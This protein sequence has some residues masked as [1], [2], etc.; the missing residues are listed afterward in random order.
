MNK[1]TVKIC[2]MFKIDD[3][4]A[5]SLKKTIFRKKFQPVLHIVNGFK[6][7]QSCMYCYFSALCFYC[8]DRGGRK[9]MHTLFCFDRDFYCYGV[10][11]HLSYYGKNAV[12]PVAL[13]GIGIHETALPHQDIRNKKLQ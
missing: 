3:E 12:Y 1:I 11:Q 9:G 5:V 4:A 6:I 10:I 7:T 8:Y 2:D 13:T